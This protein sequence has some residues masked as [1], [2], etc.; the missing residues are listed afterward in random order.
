VKQAKTS[1]EHTYSVAQEDWPYIVERRKSGKWGV[2]Y[3]ASNWI[4]KSDTCEM[5]TA[6][7]VAKKEKRKETNL[8]EG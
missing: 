4:M 7:P 5:C 3:R 1:Q 6:Q 2:V 8:E